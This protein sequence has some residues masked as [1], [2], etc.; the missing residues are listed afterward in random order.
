MLAKTHIQHLDVLKGVIILFVVMGHAFYFGFSYYSSPFYFILRRID[1]P[2]FLFLSGF[3][4]AKA[5][6][7][8]TRS[9]ADYW[10]KK[11]RQLLLPLCTLPL[12]YS[13]FYDIGLKQLLLDK[14]HGG[15]WFTLVLFEMF[16]LLF[17]ARVLDKLVNKGQHPW[18]EVSIL[19]SSLSLVWLSSPLW[20]DLHYLSWEALSWGKTSE[21]YLYFLLGYLAGRYKAVQS[22]L[23]HDVLQLIALGIFVSTVYWGIKG[24]TL[25]EHIPCS[26]SGLIV[27]YATACKLGDRPNKL[28][29]FWAYLGRESRGIYLTHFFFLF[30]AP[31]V[32]E[33]LKDLEGSKRIL[34][35]EL[36]CAGLYALLVIGLTL[37]VVHLLKSNAYLNLLCYGKRLKPKEK[38]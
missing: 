34:M 28:N 2:I 38:S 35:W 30:S 10:L 12:V 29:R 31:V 17:V 9:V 23:R 22:I 25:L 18:L 37:A 32:G 15:Y 8:D 14:M 7:F 26:T 33:F 24:Y 21:L 19:L 27:A 3:L 4:G 36:L 16:V 6:A 11:A 5:I 1:M 13:F 20:Q